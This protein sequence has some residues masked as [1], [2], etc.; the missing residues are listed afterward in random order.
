LSEC[1]TEKRK[2]YFPESGYSKSPNYLTF[3]E[4]KSSISKRSHLEP[5]TALAQ[6]T[7]V[8]ASISH[9]AVSCSRRQITI[10]T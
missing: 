3:D 6:L 8:P 4:R 5:L 1:E 9:G 10:N 7:A 2:S